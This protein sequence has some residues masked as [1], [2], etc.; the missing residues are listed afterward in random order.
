MASYSCILVDIY[1]CLSLFNRV[2]ETNIFHFQTN[3]TGGIRSEDA[4]EIFLSGTIVRS[5]TP[6][7]GGSIPGTPRVKPEPREDSATNLAEVQICPFLGSN[8]VPAISTSF[9]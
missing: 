1:I 7:E 9:T 8:L 3:N 5:S 4:T 6:D 2:P